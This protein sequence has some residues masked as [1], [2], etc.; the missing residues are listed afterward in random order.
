MGRKEQEH[1]GYL[2]PKDQF[3]IAAKV[4][5]ICEAEASQVDENLVGDMEAVVNAL[6]PRVKYTS[7]V[8]FKGSV[9]T[10]G[11]TF[12]GETE[13]GEFSAQKGKKKREFKKG[14]EEYRIGN[15]IALKFKGIKHEDLVFEPFFGAGGANLALG[16]KPVRTS[17]KYHMYSDRFELV[18]LFKSEPQSVRVGPLTATRYKHRDIW[19]NKDHK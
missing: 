10:P 4:N 11:D 6:E 17:I 14:I 12:T 3:V 8:S 7:N 16:E 1:K 19:V 5:R 2:A 9:T 18:S 15:Y 13:H